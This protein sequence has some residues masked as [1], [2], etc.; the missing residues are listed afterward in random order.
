MAAN[1]PDPM[2]QTISQLLGAPAHGER[3]A[4]RL[5]EVAAENAR[6]KLEGLRLYRPLPTQL[7]F[8]LSLASERISRGGNQ[9]GKSVSAAAEFAS[10]VT[11]IPILGPDGKPL[12]N[13]YPD[14]TSRKLLAW[15]V[16][17]DE[18]HIGSTIFRLLFQPGAFDV[19]RDR[20]TGQWRAWQP[21]IADDL[22]RK[23]ECR[24]ASPLIPSR[25]IDPKGWSWNDKAAHQFAKCTLRNGCVIE[26][27]SSRSKAKQGDQVDI[28]WIDED[29][30]Y[31]SHVAEWQARLSRRKGR[32]FWSVFPHSKNDAL[33]RMSNR[34]ADLKGAKNPD[35]EEVLLTFVDN[36]FIDADEKRKRLAGWDESE[37]RARNRG[38][39]TTDTVLMF[40]T[41]N[42][43]VHGLPR[44]DPSFLDALDEELL[45]NNYQVPGEW[46]TYVALDPGH[47]NTA[48]LVGSVPP[49]W[50][51]DWLVIHDEL[52]MRGA[53]AD[54]LAAAL[55]EKVGHRNIEAFVIDFRAGRQTPMGHGD[56]V[57][58][59]YAAAFKRYG[60]RSRATKSS[61]EWGCDNIGVRSALIREG[62]ALRSN[63]TTRL[64]F[65]IDRM[66]NT[67]REF[68][69]YRKRIVGNDIKDEPIDRDNH[70]MD[71]LGYL[72]AHRPAFVSPSKFERPMSP[73]LALFSQWSKSGNEENEG[74][75]Y[76][77][78]GRAA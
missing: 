44:R 6:R 33:V 18:G 4:R 47:T 70:C 1:N 62:L 77:G 66:P 52:F 48:A 13:K 45:K 25:L 31:P 3:E 29:I 58:D 17:Y 42:K 67:V 56:T 53:T 10:A 37:E 38:E 19:I 51:G 61:F 21:W 15:V 50:L 27:Y 49:P 22:A 76:F 9:S 14:P 68:Q 73:A 46:T 24:P 32:L 59:T 2:S 54:Q 75:V 39:F 26:A 65:F 40:P 60:L 20:Q 74:V 28:L 69:L 36:P 11:G 12:P 64:R 16:G 63:G 35:V 71:A 8:H 30:E 5:R 78:P 23:D 43:M 34:A 41:F 72:I 55:A 7:A 57:R